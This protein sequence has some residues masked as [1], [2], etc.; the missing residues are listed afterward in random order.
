MKKIKLEMHRII[1]SILCRMCW[2]VWDVRDIISPP[3]E[4]AV[5]FVAHPDDDTLFFHTFIKEWKPYVVVLTGCSSVNRLR[6]FVTNMRHYGVRYRAYDQGTDD[7]REYIVRRHIRHIMKMG[8]FTIC[9]THN[10]EGEYGHEMHKCV[11]NAVVH[12]VDCPIWVTERQAH[13]RNHPLAKTVIQEKQDI[14]RRIYWSESFVFDL[15]PH[16]IENE[17]LIE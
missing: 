9:A 16:W 5:L 4:K 10:P 6:S 14:F 11:H 7:A 2:I 8:N 3:S 12:E 13:I 17:K 15:W 1:G